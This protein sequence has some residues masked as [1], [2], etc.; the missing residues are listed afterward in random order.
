MD[1][2]ELGHQISIHTIGQEDRFE[3]ERNAPSTLYPSRTLDLCYGPLDD[4]SARHDLSL[5]HPDWID[6]L[7]I[8]TVTRLTAARVQKDRQHNGKTGPGR[9]HKFRFRL[10]RLPF[11]LFLGIGG[12]TN[13]ECQTE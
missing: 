8:E 12:R 7:G 6:R 1:T 5:L 13:S 3:A 2:L 9:N 4:R 10:E 11:L